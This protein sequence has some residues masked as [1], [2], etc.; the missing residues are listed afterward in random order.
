MRLDFLKYYYIRKY[1]YKVLDSKEY[2]RLK[3]QKTTQEN[4]EIFSKNYKFY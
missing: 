4:I 1:F 3:K 2:I